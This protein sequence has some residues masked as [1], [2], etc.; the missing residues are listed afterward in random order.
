M[1]HIILVVIVPLAMMGF[2]MAGL[3]WYLPTHSPA[4]AALRVSLS[5]APVVLPNDP[6]PSYFI[7]E[8]DHKLVLLRNLDQV[9]PHYVLLVWIMVPLAFLFGL[10]PLLM[11]IVVRKPGLI[12]MG[13]LFPALFAWTLVTPTELMW[14]GEKIVLD[15]HTGILNR[16]GVP[17]ASLT[18]LEDFGW[19]ASH[20]RGGATLHLFAKLK[21]GRQIVLGEWALRNDVGQVSGFLNAYLQMCRW[22]NRSIQPT[23]APLR[24]SEQ[25]P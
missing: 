25:H 19:M 22:P 9:E 24:Q 15:C 5:G 21:S 18:A 6:M 16:N 2:L 12:A 14:Q 13:S 23:P 8:Q 10:L 4:H 3:T 7:N 20:G 1:K 17:L 11:G